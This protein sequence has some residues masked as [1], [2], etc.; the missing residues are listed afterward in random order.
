[1]VVVAATALAIG[2]GGLLGDLPGGLLPARLSAP[3]VFGGRSEHGRPQSAGTPIRSARLGDQ[4]VSESGGYVDRARVAARG[5]SRNSSRLMRIA[6]SR[7]GSMGLVITCLATSFVVLASFARIGSSRRVRNRYGHESVR[8]LHPDDRSGI[9][10]P[11]RRVEADLGW[12]CGG[13]GF[14]DVGVP[15]GASVPGGSD[16]HPQRL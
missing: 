7:R 8:G 14:A 6:V 1:M 15:V 16:A 3:A 9:C 10:S 11:S 2:V 5:L 12:R 4:R 13:P